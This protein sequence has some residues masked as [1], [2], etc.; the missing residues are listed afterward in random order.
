MAIYPIAGPHDQEVMYVTCD[1]GCGAAVVILSG[2][3]LPDGWYEVSNNPSA[4]RHW[5]FA[6]RDHVA[7]WA[8]QSIE[9]DRKAQEITRQKLRR[10]VARDMEAWRIGQQLQAARKAR[11]LSQSQAAI[12]AGV[13]VKTLQNWEIGHRTPPAYTLQAALDKL[14]AHQEKQP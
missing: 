2:S 7:V 8:K 10:D 3:P 9:A 5:Q 4:T 1:D 6:D 11:G 13:P 14:T 12:V